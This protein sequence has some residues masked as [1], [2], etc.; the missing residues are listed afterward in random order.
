MTK[1]KRIS[2]FSRIAALQALLCFFFIPALAQQAESRVVTPLELLIH[3]KV[4]L[5]E[6]DK[7]RQVTQ[8]TSNDFADL[9]VGI[10]KEINGIVY[11]IAIDSAYSIETGW[12]FSAYASIKL[13]GSDRPLAFMAKDIGFHEKGLAADF[14]LGL[15]SAPSIGLGDYITMEFPTMFQNKNYVVFGCDGFKSASLAGNFVFAKELLVPDQT[16]AK[17]IDKVVSSFEIV[18]SNLN[19]VL[20]NVSITPFQIPDITDITFDV[21]RVVVDLSDL[22]NPA[23]LTLPKEYQDQYGSNINLWRGFYIEDSKVHLKSF[24]QSRTDSL[25]IAAKG[26]VL[27]D[28]GVSGTI[29]ATNLLTLDRGSIGSWPFSINKIGLTFQVNSLSGGELGGII[30]VPF[31]GSEGMPYEAMV[32]QGEKE[33]L[34]RFMVATASDKVFDAPFS[35]KVTLSKGSQFIIENK[36]EGFVASTKLNGTIQVVKGAENTSFTT[37][38][39][40][41]EGLVIRSTKPYLVAGTFSTEGKEDT[42]DNRFSGFPLTLDNIGLTISEQDILLRFRVGIRLANEN[43]GGFAAKT[44]LEVVV[45]EGEQSNANNARTSY[46]QFN[47]V[48]IHDISL[49]VKT[50][51]VQFYGKIAFYDKDPVYGKGFRGLVS[52]GIGGGFMSGIK[53]NAYFGSVDDYRYWHADGYMATTPFMIVP[54]YPIYINGFMGGVSD[55][56]RPKQPPSFDFSKLT[57]APKETKDI[58]QT[59]FD[60]RTS[61]QLE[62]YDPGEYVPD[63]DAGLSLMFGVTLYAVQE[64]VFNADARVEVTFNPGG[65]LRYIQFDCNGYFFTRVNSRERVNGSNPPPK[66]I[67]WGTSRTLFDNVNKVFHSNLKVYVDVFGLVKGAGPN[68]LM[69]ESVIHFDRN[70]WYIYMGRPSAMDGLEFLGFAKFKSYFMM[71][72]KIEPMAPPPSEMLEIFNNIEMGIMRDESMIASGRGFATGHR[73]RVGFDS[74]RK[75]RPFYVR[76]AIGAGADIMLRNFGNAYCAGRNGPVGMNGW[77]ASGQAYAYF[78]GQVGIRVKGHD[79]DIVYLGAGALLQAQLPNPTWF[80]GRLAGRYRLLGGLIKGRFH[81]KITIGDPCELINPGEEIDDIIVIA[82]IKPEVGTNDAS[83]FTAPQV[84]FNTAINTEFKMMDTQDRVNSYRVKLQEFAVTAKGSVQP[85]SVEWN[86]TND[87]AIFRTHEILPPQSELKAFVKVFWERKPANG[88]WEVIK[89]IKGQVI[90]E[91]KETSFTTGI[92]PSFIP[93]ENI[94][95]SYPAKGQYNFHINEYGTGYIKLQ[96]GQSYLFQKTEGDINWNYNAKFQDAKKSTIEVPLTYDPSKSTIT[97]AVPPSLAKQT[98]YNLTFVKRPETNGGIDQNVK[99]ADVAVNAGEGNEMI[100]TSNTLEGTIAQD[101]EKEIYA[102]AFRTSRFGR[103]EE[104]WNSFSR[105]QDMFD[106]AQGNV[107]VIGKRGTIQETFDEFELKGNRANQSR[108]LVQ[109][110][111]SPDIAWLREDISP[112]LY[113]SYPI[114]PDVDIDWRRPIEKMGLKPVKAV[115]LE[116]DQDGEYRLTEEDLAAGA[117]TKTGTVLIGYYLSFYCYKDYYELTNKTVAKYL[118][119]WAGAPP[120]AKKLLSLEG[121]RD[122][123]SGNYYPVDIVYSLPG[124]DQVTYRNQVSIKF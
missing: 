28:L 62:A 89:D 25:V 11:V 51:G 84:S 97:F 112:Y 91:T 115:R 101:V 31:L 14:K 106:V 99:R 75:L 2:F 15:V 53:V 38:K 42:S 116:N 36:P 120:A 4:R 41:F 78:I 29:S 5:V 6:E 8:L 22:K 94:S 10:A 39:L 9:P 95:Y 63:K 54:P 117:P 74:G 121:Y 24:N 52:M 86:S 118:N 35:A 98:V 17:G 68:N 96:T 65:G 66:S 110:A 82:D 114:A 23:G 70:D 21:K 76:L 119:N 113:D 104:K 67:V 105:G 37:T 33:L 32:E 123:R 64:N 71:G 79:F 20:L 12:F 58:T 7:S 103:F 16:I 124:I 45:R 49:D 55:R 69:G 81:L 34:Y 92:A 59:M 48:R 50:S 100:R 30:G 19:D 122:L 90:Y 47:R 109:I 107:A 40:N 72:T 88:V 93:E 73:F 43:S 85:G 27:D 60:A 46:W 77:Y 111:A 102:S 57:N 83:V 108:P 1:P 61:S 13:P 44:S 18:T 3:S 80:S 87:V 26:L 56:M